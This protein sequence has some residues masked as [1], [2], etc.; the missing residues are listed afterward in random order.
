ML[1]TWRWY[2]KTVGTTSDFGKPAWETEEGN[3]VL[4]AGW[5]G[6]EL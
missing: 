1:A 4:Q 5:L 6:A 3:Q 2:R